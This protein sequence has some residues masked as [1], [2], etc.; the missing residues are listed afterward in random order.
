MSDQFLLLPAATLLLCSLFFGVTAAGTPGNPTLRGHSD[1]H[2]DHHGASHH[3]T[4]HHGESD[5]HGET[6]ATDLS[7]NYHR[8][9]KVKQ[10]HG[11]HKSSAQLPVMAQLPDFV[12]TER[13]GQEMSA[14]DLQAKAWVVDFIF[15]SCQDECPLMNLEMQKVQKAFPEGNI[16]MLSFSVDPENDTPERLRTYAD[17]F[18]AGPHWLFFTGERDKL[19]QLAIQDFKLSVQERVQKHG[20]KDHH[21]HGTSPFLHSQKFVLV[22]DQRRIRGYYDSRDPQAIKQLIEVDLPAL[23]AES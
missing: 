1:H 2:N 15:T 23:V 17:Q 5:H 13:T 18:E 22:D 14:N 19:H 16:K 12:F 6:T 3:G 11:S 7:E 10:A 9:Q 8:Q 21:G 20:G 4:S